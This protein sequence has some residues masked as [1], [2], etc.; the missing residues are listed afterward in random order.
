MIRNLKTLFQIK[1]LPCAHIDRKII[2]VGEQV[3]IL[4]EFLC[5][6]SKDDVEKLHSLG[7]DSRLYSSTR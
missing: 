5:P 2:M 3:R 4:K 7:Q 6:T 1:A